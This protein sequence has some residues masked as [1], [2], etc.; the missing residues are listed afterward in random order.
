MFHQPHL[1][2]STG[3]TILT[4]HMGWG[5]EIAVC[6]ADAQITPVHAVVLSAGLHVISV[7]LTSNVQLG[8]ACPSAE[9][10]AVLCAIGRD[11]QPLSNV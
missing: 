3:E 9:V 8:S 4:L 11:F 2:A 7:K 1:P 5:D 10:V 6:R